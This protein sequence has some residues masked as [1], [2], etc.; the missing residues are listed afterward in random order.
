MGEGHVS[1]ASIAANEL[2]DCEV[3]ACVVREFKQL[4]F[5]KFESG[6]VTAAYPLSF[7]P[8]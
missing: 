2:P 5:P 6:I 3:T 4:V 1:K 7:K 8:D